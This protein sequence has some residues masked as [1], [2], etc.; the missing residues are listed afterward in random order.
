VRECLDVH[1]YVGRG[2]PVRSAI[3]DWSFAYA[4]KSLSDFHQLRAAA[5]A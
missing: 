2:A 5:K 3:V 1:G 4:D